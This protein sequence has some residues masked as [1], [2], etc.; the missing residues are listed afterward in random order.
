MQL[1]CEV[2]IKAAK[3]SGCWDQRG[4]GAWGGRGRGALCHALCGLPLASPSLRGQVVSE[5]LAAAGEP[6]PLHLL[7]QED[8]GGPRPLSQTPRFEP[9]SEPERSQ[10]IR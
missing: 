10:G 3:L 4:G 9:G 2:R 6:E 7:A 8:R 5:S 1:P